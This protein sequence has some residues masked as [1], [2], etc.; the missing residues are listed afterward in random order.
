MATRLRPR[1]T[2]HSAT[3]PGI[4][5][6]RSSK[7]KSI[8]TLAPPAELGSGWGTT[9]LGATTPVRRDTLA[10]HLP[11]GTKRNNAPALLAN[12]SLNRTQSHPSSCSRQDV[13]CSSL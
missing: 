11:I 6:V 5:L 9:A 1:H 7:S 13:F 12:A 8:L 4:A 2:P 10:G 3:S